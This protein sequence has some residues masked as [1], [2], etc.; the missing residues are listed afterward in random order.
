[1]A[2]ILVVWFA[3]YI[4]LNTLGRLTLKFTGD[5][6]LPWYG[7]LMLGYCT[8]SSISVILSLFI[9]LNFYCFIALFTGCAAYFFSKVSR[10]G[11]QFTKPKLAE[12]F[13][14]LLVL[15][16]TVPVPNHGDSAFYH[17]QALQWVEK[18]SV[19]PGL[20][21]FFGRLAFNSS[22]F[23]TEALFSFYPVSDI[24]SRFLN[25]FLVMIWF[26]FLY[27]KSTD[28]NET[29]IVRTTAI[30]F[31]LISILVSRG[32][33][34]SI[35]PDVTTGLFMLIITFHF[36]LGIL[37]QEQSSPIYLIILILTA[38]TIKL[39]A[40][41][42]LPILFFYPQFFQKYK[43]KLFWI[44]MVIGLPWVVRNIILSGYLVYPYLPLL[45]WKPDWLV[46]A[47]LAL[48]ER[49]WISSWARI[50][51]EPW[52]Y[53]L[54][55]PFSS[56]FPHWFKGQYLINQILVVLFCV[57]FLWLIFKLFLSWYA[58]Q[59]LAPI[60]RLLWVWCGVIFIW[61]TT[62]PDFRFGYGLIVPFLLLI[63][64]NQ[65]NAYLSQK[66]I[67][68]KPAQIG[69]LTAMLLLTVYVIQKENTALHKYVVVPEPYPVIES[70]QKT[71]GAQTIQ[72]APGDESCWNCP[73]PCIND[74][75]FPLHLEMRGKSVQQG[76][77]QKK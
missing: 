46:P 35:A 11:L 20:A 55:L 38:I 63:F 3:H 26:V 15:I 68:L 39:P 59:K 57:A 66:L 58:E 76:F 37:K 48:I 24:S 64:L 72:V 65:F 52:Q 6:N 44:P 1:M 22:F 62:A 74:D 53:V 9:P 51:A 45:V 77:R 60:H 25:G 41:L 19:V 42:L 5:L 61:F 2:I 43:R 40:A 70:F 36:I 54:S 18:Y 29:V 71:I 69:F 67:W 73:L 4:I 31:A 34:S 13:I 14:A 7:E 10:S 30:L 27:R 28:N 49:A 23:T 75:L 17:A 16:L 47:D 56:W 12:V 50:P 33:V 32:W 21:N 8:L